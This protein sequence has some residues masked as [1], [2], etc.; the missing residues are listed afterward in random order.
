VPKSLWRSAG[1]RNLWVAQSVSLVGSQVTLLAFPLLALLV[2][3]SSASQVSDLWAVEYLPVLLLGLPAG[4]WIER[5]RRRPVLI[6]SDIVR[7]VATASIP[8]AYWLGVLGLG[9]LYVVAFVIG[10]GT[11]FSDVGQL[12]YLPSLIDADQLGDGNARLEGSRS[13]AQFAGPGIG[14]ILVQIFTAPVAI[15]VDA[16]SYAVSAL[17]L[18][19]IR[20]H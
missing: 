19:G 5:M 12:S 4:T 2:L 1:F 6:A 8:V 3:H 11:L 17:L 7:G 14:G 15:V 16:V 20:H 18:A 9:Q 13:V 10:L